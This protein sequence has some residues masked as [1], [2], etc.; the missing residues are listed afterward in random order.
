VADQGFGTASSNSVTLHELLRSVSA[1]LKVNE[2]M[3]TLID[4]IPGGYADIRRKMHQE[5]LRFTATKVSLLDPVAIKCLSTV[6]QRL[7]FVQ[8]DLL[9]VERVP[10]E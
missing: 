6:F 1:R 10:S 7:K 9:W 8:I 3:A 4:L 2:V 5:L